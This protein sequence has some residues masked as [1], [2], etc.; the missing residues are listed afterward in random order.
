MSTPPR[1]GPTT[2]P[3]VAANTHHLRA[4]SSLEITA[5]R[6]GSEPASSSVAPTPCAPRATSSIGSVVDAPATTE[7]TAKIAVPASTSPS[8]GRRR[9]RIVTG[10]ATIG[11]DEGVGRQHPRDADDRRVELGVEVGQRQRDDRRI[12]ERQGDRRD[13]QHGCDHDRPVMAP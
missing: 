2:A 13:E 5:A 6:T 12:G 3:T 7:A 4:R 8:G 11:D 1:A 9:W 10:T